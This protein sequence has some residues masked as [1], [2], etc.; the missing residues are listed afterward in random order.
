VT[1]RLPL[2]PRGC[3]RI[4]TPDDLDRA[5]ELAILAALAHTLELAAT[6]LVCAHPDL[7]DPERPSWLA[8]RTRSVAIAESLMSRA[9]GLQHALRD[10]RR[11]VEIPL[12]EDPPDLDDLDF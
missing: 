5:P 8:A 2:Q 4:P 10:Y 7:C 3:D 12:R 11:A 9:R 1:R 6:A